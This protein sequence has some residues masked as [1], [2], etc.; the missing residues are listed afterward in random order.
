MKARRYAQ[1]RCHTL[2]R[3]IWITRRLICRREATGEWQLLRR[4][5]EQSWQR[6]C[7]GTSHLILAA[8]IV[9]CVTGKASAQTAPSAQPVAA[10]LVG[11]VQV[12]S[13]LSI[14]VAENRPRFGIVPSLRTVYDSNV[15]RFVVSQNGPRDNL[16]VTPGI[17]IDY[18]RLIGRVLLG[19]RGSAGYDLNSR[20]K[21][22]NRSRINFSGSAQAP[23]GAI[24]SFN[25]A[26]SY[27]RAT[28][29]L[30][31]TQTDVIRSQAGA[32]S[33]IQD[34]SIDAGCKRAA[35]LSPT[36]EIQYQKLDNSQLQLL[37]VRRYTG[38]F[39]IAYARP[40]LG[41]IALNAV[42]SHIGRPVVN[43]L[44]GINDD[45]DIYGFSVG[46]NREVSPRLRL[47]IS[48]GLSKAV[49]R[50]DSVP[51][52]TGVAYNGLLE[53]SPN[54]RI[55]ITGVLSRQV[56]GQ[57]GINAT[58]VIREDYTLSAGYRLSAKSQITLA[59]TRTKRDFRGQA[60][61]SSFEPLGAD[62]LNNLS[63][64]YNY[65]VTPRLR[66]GLGLGHRWRKAD[67]PVY[68]YKSTVLSS[69]IGAHF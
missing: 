17:D 7:F 54:S 4:E 18:N 31:D 43:D 62:T 30:N 44:T 11:Q 32:V 65:D 2:I 36:A 68:N 16:R 61:V 63:A 25:A 64:N 9:G 24:C 60:L 26:A 1:A 59:G 12:R 51:R 46:I 47:N 53:W 14:A 38:N 56:T 45:T 27:N 52:F 34:Y 58:Y 29:D 6:S 39:G 8:S 13:P 49:P 55:V 20:F 23:V 22:L 10:P 19:V 33:T 42:Y 37:D 48:G 15:L 69:S 50:R 21:V 40:S 35:G 5:S 3:A 28:F 41:T 66:L 57:N 67:N